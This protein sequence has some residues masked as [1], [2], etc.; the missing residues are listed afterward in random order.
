MNPLMNAE[1]VARLITLTDPEFDQYYAVLSQVVRWRKD[2]ATQPESVSKALAL[3]PAPGPAP[4]IP[5]AA[6]LLPPRP[7]M[8]EP[9]P[10][11]M[12][13]VVHEILRSSGGKP[14]KRSELADE[15]VRRTG[16]P[17]ENV[18][19]RVTEILGSP[20]DTRI[21]RVGHG[22]YIYSANGEEVAQ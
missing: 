7:R 4:Q 6:A 8:A 14:I 9:R 22:L 3:V 12:R 19:P 10:G 2:F 18:I 5:A 15:V 1:H 17:R 20:H 11:S 21:K 13:A 16:M